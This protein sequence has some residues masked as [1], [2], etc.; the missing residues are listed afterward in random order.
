MLAALYKHMD[1]DG[2]SC[3]PG[4]LK[5]AVEAGCRESTVKKHL[6]LAEEQGWI[7]KAYRNRA[8]GQSWRGRSYQARIPEE[9]LNKLERGPADGSPAD[10]RWS[11]SRSK[12]V[13]ETPEGGPAEYLEVVRE[14]DTNRPLEQ[15]NEQTT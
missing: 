6:T 5:I 12:V 9:A 8:S 13:R 7:V 4:I 11:G 15:T 1:E 2:G 10:G 3:F 14:P